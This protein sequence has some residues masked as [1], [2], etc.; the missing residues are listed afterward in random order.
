LEW[1]AEGDQKA[2]FEDDPIRAVHKDI[3]LAK[4]RCGQVHGLVLV[5][6]RILT[7]LKEISLEL[8]CEKGRG[9]EHAKWSPVGIQLAY[10]Y[11]WC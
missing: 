3:L 1:I 7:L 10:P 5:I 2:K 8:H 4:L 11:F 6:W 9:K